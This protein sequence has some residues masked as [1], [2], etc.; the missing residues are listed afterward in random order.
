MKLGD[1]GP[2]RLTYQGMEVNSQSHLLLNIVSSP[3]H[4]GGLT[5]AL[6]QLQSPFYSSQVQGFNQQFYRSV[7]SQ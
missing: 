6:R 4:P 2:G 5:A 3:D 1:L 7:L